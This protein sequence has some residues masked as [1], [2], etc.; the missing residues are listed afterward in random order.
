MEFICPTPY[1]ASVISSTAHVIF[2]TFCYIY[3]YMYIDIHILFDLDCIPYV[4]YMLS[5]VRKMYMYSYRLSIDYTFLWCTV[6]HRVLGLY[7]ESLPSACFLFL[8]RHVLDVCALCQHLACHHASLL[9][10]ALSHLACV[11]LTIHYHC[12]LSD[13]WLIARLLGLYL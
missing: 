7:V 1:V 2:Y 10:C 13:A 5:S 12:S 6:Y 3:I 8:M 11:G 9:G 4:S